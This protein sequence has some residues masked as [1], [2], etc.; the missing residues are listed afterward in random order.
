MSTQPT[1]EPEGSSATPYLGS[2]TAPRAMPVRA[3][4]AEDLE[5]LELKLQACLQ[6]LAEEDAAFRGYV[7][8]GVSEQVWEQAAHAA[9]RAR[10]TYERKRDAILIRT[11]RI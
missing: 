1:R 8:G 4:S 10:F 9:T 5:D 11:G 7:V 6:L 3:A 2:S